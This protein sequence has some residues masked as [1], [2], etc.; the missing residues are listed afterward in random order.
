MYYI[1][2]V[3]YFV[4]KN[5]HEVMTPWDDP[6]TLKGVNGGGIM[7]QKHRLMFFIFY[8]LGNGSSA[9]H[10]WTVEYSLLNFN[11]SKVILMV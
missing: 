1:Q 3:I 4:K 11:Y 9:I 7:N 8:F 5:I 6:F 10:I 2:Y